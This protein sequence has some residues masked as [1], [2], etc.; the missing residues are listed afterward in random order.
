MRKDRLQALLHTVPTSV[1]QCMLE[2]RPACKHAQTTSN[3]SK[4]NFLTRR[5]LR[6]RTRHSLMQSIHVQLSRTVIPSRSRAPQL[7]HAASQCGRIYQD[8]LSMFAEASAR[9][10][11]MTRTEPEH[12]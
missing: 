1:S 8:D 12:A 3:D 9:T 6:I 5:L 4:W 11:G 2:D 7:R 10:S